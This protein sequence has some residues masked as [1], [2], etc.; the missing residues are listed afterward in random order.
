[1]YKCKRGFLIKQGREVRELHLR[2]TPSDL[3]LGA[4]TCKQLLTLYKAQKTAV[5]FLQK[6]LTLAILLT[7]QTGG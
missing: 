3:L 6:E 7:L 5:S 1:M 2:E 4:F